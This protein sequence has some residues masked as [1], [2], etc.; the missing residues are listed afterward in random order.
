M[1]TNF[2]AASIAAANSFSA[3][4]A[5][6]GKFNFNLSGTWVG[7]VVVQRSFNDGKSWLDV[8]EFTANGAYVGDEPEA[9]VLYRFG[10]KTGALTSGD[11]IGRLSQ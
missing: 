1:N 11:V 2:I 5:L 8:A 3:S 4:I 7:T 10:V 9:G 6:A